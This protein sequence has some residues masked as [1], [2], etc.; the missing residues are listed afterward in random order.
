MGKI[1]D[2]WK[3]RFASNNI[4]KPVKEI[5]KALVGLLKES[6]VGGWT[7]RGEDRELP[8]F[9]EMWDA[10]NK[11]YFENELLSEKVLLLNFY[12]LMVKIIE[13]GPK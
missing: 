2:M 4:T 9:L 8:P 13:E 7:D 5:T 11:Q 1:D 6:Y 10:I 12:N 3:K